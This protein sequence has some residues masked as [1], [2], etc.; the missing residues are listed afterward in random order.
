MR[1]IDLTSFRVASSE[2]ARLINRRIAL[3]L[4]RHHPPMSRADL[5]RRSGLQR[6]TVSAIIDQLIEEGWVTEGVGRAPRGR[7]PRLLHLNVERASLVAVEVRPERTT[8]G[9][10]GIDARFVEQ[11]TWPTPADAAGFV[12]ELART[13]DAFRAAHPRLICEGLGVSLPGRVDA[14]GRLVFAPNL[15]WGHVDLKARIEAATRLPVAL[16]NA[17]NACALAELWFGRHADHVR[18][19]IAVT[20][21]EGIGVGLLLNG[22]LVHGGA[23]MAGEF[24]HLTLEEDGPECPCGKR[25]CWERYASSSAALRFYAER[26]SRARRARRLCRPVVAGRERRR[27]GWRGHRS[28]GEVPRC[29]PGRPRHRTESR[30]DRHHRRGH[31]RVGSR[32]ADRQ[33][34][35]RPALAVACLDADRSHRSG[36]AAPSARRRDARHPAALRRAQRRMTVG[37]PP[38]VGRYRW[39][40]CALLFAA[41]AINYIDRQVLGLLKPTLQQEL[42]W[43]EIDYG[44]LVLTFQLAYAIGLL[45]WGRFV[46]RIGP[47]AGFTIAILVWSVAAA[48]HGAAVAIGGPAAAVFGL[49]GIAVSHTIAGFI[50]ARFLLGLG[51]AAMFPVGIKAIAEWFPRRE[52][53]F[54]AGLFNAG[55]NIGA[56]VAPLAV[57]ALTLAFG[58]QWAFIATG[59]IGVVWVVAWVISYAPPERHAS[60]QPAELAYINSD[61][62]DSTARSAVARDSPA[63]RRLGV[64]VR[65]VADRPGLVDLSVLDPRLPQPAVPARFADDGPADRGDFSRRRRGQHRR[66]L[67]VVT[68]DQGRLERESR[69]QDDDADLRAGGGTDRGR[70]TNVKPLG[71]RRSHRARHRGAPGLVGEPLHA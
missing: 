63:S 36:A 34:R 16:E 12:R 18:N 39:W 33:R 50:A 42:G 23:A 7:R 4:I 49:A 41:S 46:D 3:S 9:L 52:R 44:N 57:P 21:S 70:G 5:A 20:V 25:G 55:T 8:V 38:T 65:Q 30:G 48:G 32:R 27:G 45:S 28:D 40:I 13:V 47:G 56:I 22:Q 51:E 53:A 64:R 69:P 26:A 43:S 6:S 37:H 10:A 11:T 58:W 61:P 1:K 24:G 2:T 14:D 35:D 19:L 31:R 60:L 17:A 54:A 71:R 67:A 66:R 59:A 68:P 15:R 29:R 62:P